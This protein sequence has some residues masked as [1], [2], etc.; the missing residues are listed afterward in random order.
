MHKAYQPFRPAANKY[1]QKKWDE[2]H[3]AEHRKK[4]REA[5]PTVDTKGIQTPTHIQVKLKKAQVQEERQAIINRDNQLLASR[6]ADIQHSKGRIDHRNYYP[7]RSLNSE[8]RRAKLLQV[9]HEN[10]AIYERITAQ[11]S[12]YRRELWEEDWVRTEQRRDSIT[13]YPRGVAHKQKR[14][15][16]VKFLGGASV[17]TLSSSSRTQDGETTDEDLQ[18]Q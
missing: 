6:L 7:E 2:E 4:V 18:H 15:K 1:L 13:R 11:Q 8:S 9:A 5:K 12:E 10:Q 3:Y 14:K 16:S 17:Q